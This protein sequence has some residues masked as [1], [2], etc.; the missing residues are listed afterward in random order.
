MTKDGLRFVIVALPGTFLLPFL[1]TTPVV[2]VPCGDPKK[3]PRTHLMV[4]LFQVPEFALYNHPS[5]S[6]CS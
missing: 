2:F 1:Y 5:Y 6:S 4:L 3:S